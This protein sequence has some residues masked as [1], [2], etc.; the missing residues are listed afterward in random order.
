MTSVGLITA[1]VYLLRCLLS[2]RSI[3]NVIWQQKLLVVVCMRQTEPSHYCET[4]VCDIF[5]RVQC[6]TISAR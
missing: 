3:G 1:V 2:T 4:S 5:P 6:N